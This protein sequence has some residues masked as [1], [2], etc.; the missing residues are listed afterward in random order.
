VLLG[1]TIP[2]PQSFDVGIV[3]GVELQELTPATREWQT[4]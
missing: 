2:R 4:V 1:A 3:K